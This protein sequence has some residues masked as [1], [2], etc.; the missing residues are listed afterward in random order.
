MPTLAVGNGPAV[1]GS[2]NTHWETDRSLG[3]LL[4]AGT[5][6]QCNCPELL[7]GVTSTRPVPGRYPDWLPTRVQRS[8]TS[9]YS[10]GPRGP[11]LG[12]RTRWQPLLKLKRGACSRAHTQGSPQPFQMHIHPTTSFTFSTTLKESWVRSPPVLGDPTLAF[13][14]ISSRKALI[15]FSLR[16]QD[17]C[18][19]LSSTCHGSQA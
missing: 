17:A 3:P 7:S 8:M 13:G 18:R 6:S 4:R 11:T 2:K 14:D 9:G 19:D 10:G 5:S 16:N 12:T 1:R 15:D